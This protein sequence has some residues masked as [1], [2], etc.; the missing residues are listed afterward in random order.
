MRNKEEFIAALNN[1]AWAL[2]TRDAT[3]GGD[4][5]KAVPLAERAASEVSY[6]NP[7]VLDTLAVA[8]AAAGRYS[9]AVHRREGHRPGGRAA[10]W[11]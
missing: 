3:A 4:S 9:E 6:Q 11:N 8:Y 2:A 10:R 7:S 1:R 5:A